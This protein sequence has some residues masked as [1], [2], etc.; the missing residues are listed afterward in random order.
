MCGSVLSELA[1]ERPQRLVE[2]PALAEASDR[3]CPVAADSHALGVTQVTVAATNQVL[4]QDVEG[5]PEI[6]CGIP[7][8][9]RSQQLLRAEK[10]HNRLVGFP[11]Q[12]RRTAGELDPRRL[13]E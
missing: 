11:T 9:D 7:V 5:R 3:P 8:A 4:L 2:I 1:S 6:G 12:R 10:L 13:R